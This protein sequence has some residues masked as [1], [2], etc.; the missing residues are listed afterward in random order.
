MTEEKEKKRECQIKGRVSN[1]QGWLLTQRDVG[2]QVNLKQK[3]DKDK[4]KIDMAGEEE[5]E[6]ENVR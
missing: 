6:K 2:K 5:E 1:L 3:E 4:K